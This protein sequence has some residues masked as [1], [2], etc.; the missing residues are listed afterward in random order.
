[1]EKTV[2]ELVVWME[3]FLREAGHESALRALAF[4]QGL[5]ARE[6]LK[7][8]IRTRLAR[9]AA[10]GLRV[11]AMLLDLDP[12]ISH[13]EMDTLLSAVLLHVYPENFPF[14]DAGEKLA[15]LGF[16]PEVTALV[17]TIVP[18]REGD[19][20][21]QDAY[22]Q[23]VQENPLALLAVLADRGD[24]ATQLYRLS[25]WN[26]HRYIDETKACYY[27]MCIYGKE[28]YHGLLAAINVLTEKIRTLV[29]VSEILLTRYEVREAELTEDILTLREENATIRGI[30]D[31]FEAEEAAVE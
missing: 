21:Q 15:S 30:I 18:E 3:P 10:H 1:M 9:E 22:Y 16:A 8:G 4:V 31:Q 24:L 20:G 6:D 7:E 19:D 17:S 14:E 26:A 12:A 2:K 28:H 23:R 13:G 5:T 11:C 27:P 29:E 25:T